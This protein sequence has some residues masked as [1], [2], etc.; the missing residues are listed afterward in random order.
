MVEH[1]LLLSRALCAIFQDPTLSA[2]LRFRGGTAIHKLVMPRPGRFSEDLD[3]IYIGDAPMRTMLD[4]L[5]K[6]MDWFK[7]EISFGRGGKRFDFDFIPTDKPDERQRMKI[8]FNTTENVFAEAPIQYHYRVVNP[9][10]RGAASVWSFPP[11][12]LMG[13][14]LHALLSRDKVRDLFDFYDTRARVDMD[15][16]SVMRAFTF[17][18]NQRG[19]TYAPDAGSSGAEIAG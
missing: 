5:W 9:W 6:A 17:Y 14:K 4:C 7:G 1:D 3:L 15:I 18:A 8:E 11:E 10:Y 13:S 19:R 16:D 12:D 2:V